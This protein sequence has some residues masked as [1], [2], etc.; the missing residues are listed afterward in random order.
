MAAFATPESVSKPLSQRI[1]EKYDTDGSGD[2]DVKEF[3]KMVRDQGIYLSEDALALAVMELDRDGNCKISYEEYKTWKQNSAF[4]DLDIDD[5]TVANRL[6]IADTFEKYDTDKNGSLSLD[7]LK[8]FHAELV[9]CELVTGDAETL[10]RQID[11]DGDG[12]VQFSELVRYMERAF[13]E[14]ADAKPSS[15]V[16]AAAAIA[17]V[18]AASSSPARAAEPATQP[19]VVPVTP[20]VAAG[21]TYSYEQ[22]KC[23]IAGVDPTRKEEYLD[24]SEFLE[25]FGVDKASF[26]ALPKWKRDAQKKKL[27]LF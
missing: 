9:E 3:H 11:V 24:D 19:V 22:L 2:I 16:A 6:R 17:A 12:A 27:S 8:L 7:E 5:D 1:F 25:L 14:E 23:P 21:T 10:L 18:A 4:S 26:A 15:Q 13:T 20:V